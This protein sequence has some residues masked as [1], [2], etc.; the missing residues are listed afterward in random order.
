MMLQNVI[1]IE[2]ARELRALGLQI[3][4]VV[5]VAFSRRAEK[6]F[7][8]ARKAK[9]TFYFAFRDYCTTEPPIERLFNR[10]TRAL[11]KITALSEEAAQFTSSH[12]GEAFAVQGLLTHPMH[13]FITY[14]EQTLSMVEDGQGTSVF[15]T[16]E[17]LD[18]WA[19][20][21]L[22]HSDDPAA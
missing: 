10:M 9:T 16:Q 22:P 3:L 1:N 7:I 17:M 5:D 12:H 2:D 21:T 13:Q 14:W 11:K 18:G 8:K 20:P 15:I 6:L 4:P 19:V